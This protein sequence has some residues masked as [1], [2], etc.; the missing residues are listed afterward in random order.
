MELLIL[1][2]V[3][4]VVLAPIVIVGRWILGPIDRAA[5]DREVP[6][7][8]S[9][10]DFLCLFLAV[11]I[12]LTVVYQFVGSD[13][14]QLFWVF[15]LITWIIAPV[16]WFA[17]ARALSRAGVA[18]GT[19]R[20]VFLGLIMPAVY[21]GLMPFVLFSIYI[22]V[23]LT[24]DHH[25]ERPWQP[26]WYLAAWL[27]I[28]TIFA[29]SGVFTRWIIRQAQLGEPPLSEREGRDEFTPTVLQP[30]PAQPLA[31]DESKDA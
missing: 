31:I 30:A 18:S 17:C 27:A 3:I 9:I 14:E 10:G 29:V 23:D 12:P 16:I 25:G 19:H 5:R 1:C 21:Y 2:V 20:F 28:T 4:I 26:G 13:G 8:F 6:V 24:I 22:M 15:T 7:R 11:Q